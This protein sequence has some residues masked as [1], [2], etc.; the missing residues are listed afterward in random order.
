MNKLF[1]R[2]N[3]ALACLLCIGVSACS[4]LL[5]LS[6]LA[7]FGLSAEIRDPN[8]TIERRSEIAQGLEN[9]T[10]VQL[11]LVN[12]IW[13]LSLMAILLI[14]VVALWGFRRGSAGSENQRT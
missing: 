11:R 3:L 9:G 5:Y 6:Y 14:V 1:A 8:T 4:S 12:V 13:W 2:L 7:A 10:A